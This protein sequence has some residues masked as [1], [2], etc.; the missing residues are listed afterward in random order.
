MLRRQAEGN[1]PRRVHVRGLPP[2]LLPNRF[3]ART[4]RKDGIMFQ[5]SRTNSRRSSRLLV[6]QLEDRCVPA[7]FVPVLSALDAAFTAHSSTMVQLTGTF[8]DTDT[9]DPHSVI[10]DWHDNSP[11][12]TVPLTQ[13]A[14]T[15]QVTHLYAN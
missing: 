3:H 11:T 1:T 7:N 10:I 5:R 9:K 8:T 4:G 15:F 2:F 12:Q 14:R 13:G 6:E